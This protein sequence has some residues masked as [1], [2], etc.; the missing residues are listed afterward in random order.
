MKD[1]P[2]DSVLLNCPLPL[3]ARKTIQ[4]G[5]GS[6]GKMSSDLVRD[7]ILK[8]FTNPILDRLGDS[9]ELH[10]EDARLAFTTDSF[11]VDPIF[12]PGGDI[13]DLAVNGTLNDLAVVGAR[14][15]CLSAG[16]I[17]EEGFAIADLERILASMQRAASN[18]RV[19][20]VTGDTKVV[21]RGKADKIFIN[22][23]GLGAISATIALGPERIAVG[24]SIIVSGPIGNHGI[25]V[26]SRREG[27]SFGTDV[28][29]DTASILPL[30]QDLIATCGLNL[31]LMRDPTRGGVAATLNEFAQGA[32]LEIEIDESSL[33]IDPAVASA[34]ELLGIDP[35]YIANEGKVVAVVAEHAAEGALDSLRRHT[36]AERAAIIGHVVGSDHPGRVTLKTR[37]GTRRMVD[38]PVAEQLPRIC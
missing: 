21:T 35:L 27:F 38:L 15:M 34:C 9:A 25:A 18:A 31:H 8:H 13:G 12:F 37:L 1:K 20:I 4:L 6:G 11:V 26:L 16:L 3:P 24:D 14:P 19:P 32:R 7:I 23:S 17:I 22:T 2:P 36:I 33:P 28:A 5:H 10:V 30:T 29:S